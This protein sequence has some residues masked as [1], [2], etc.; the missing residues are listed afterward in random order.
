MTAIII[1]LLCVVLG[2]GA[3]LACVCLAISWGILR[4]PSSEDM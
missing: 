1:G 2:A 3:V 4:P